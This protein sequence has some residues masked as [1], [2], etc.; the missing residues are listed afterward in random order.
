[1]G[2]KKRLADH[3][4]V[5]WIAGGAVR[6]FC[7]GRG[8]DE[9][10]LVT[11]AT[12][13]VLKSL[14][15]EAV[16]VGESFGVLKIPT[17]AGDFFDLATFR[18]ESDYIDGRRPSHVEAATPTKDGQRRDFTV[19]AMFW[20]DVREVIVDD[21]GGREALATKRLVCVGDPEIRFTEDYLR[22]LR[23][24]RFA[25]VLGFSM[26]EK[27]YAAAS[28]HLGGLSK[29]SGERI[30]AELKKIK[31]PGNWR[32]VLE[33]NLMRDL[34][35][36]LIGEGE[37]RSQAVSESVT[38]TMAVLY[39]L[40]PE[41]DLT[42]FLKQ[43]LKVSNNELQLYQHIKFLMQWSP[44]KSS[45][46]L[47]FAVEKNPALRETFLS[48]VKQKLLLK[49]SAEKVENLLVLYPQALISAQEISELI[50]KH[51][52][53][54]EFKN[55]RLGQLLGTF[56]TKEQVLAY[57]SEKYAEKNEKT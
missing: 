12:T 11:D 28:R 43:K 2:V 20:D 4:F 19:N 52:T 18:Q 25:A 40:R 21:E 55:L 9:F 45:A 44:E 47:A 27:T 6:D 7:L 15:P 56:Q 16:L 5:C 29:I 17:G 24:L 31:Y 48:L 41:Q 26:E 51:L 42:P 34:L 14:F 53:S 1:M 33:N 23:L 35:Y 32:F 37:L 36:S 30:W 38:E 50:P 8:V 57:L 49:N 22:I 10:D 3:Q 13:D 54:E 39:L 46:E